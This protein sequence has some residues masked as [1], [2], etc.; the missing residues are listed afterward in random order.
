[1]KKDK[2]DY[3]PLIKRRMKSYNQKGQKSM[4]KAGQGIRASHGRDAFLNFN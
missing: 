2:I 1:M 4:D 3:I